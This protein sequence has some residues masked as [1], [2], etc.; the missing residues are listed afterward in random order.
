M[1][2][3]EIIAWCVALIGALTL[4]SASAD[5]ITIDGVTWLYSV[6]GEFASI[7]KAYPSSG[8]LSIPS[9]LSWYTVKSIG[10]SAFEGRSGLTSVTIPSSVSSII[11]ERIT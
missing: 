7:E 5:E 11:C 6:N 2:Q 10:R 9:S 8:S 1:K 4:H 3:R